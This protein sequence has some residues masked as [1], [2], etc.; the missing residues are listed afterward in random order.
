MAM[1]CGL[2]PAHYEISSLINVLD[3]HAR[4]PQGRVYKASGKQSGL[5]WEDYS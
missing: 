2:W 3:I 5:T 1:A 4:L